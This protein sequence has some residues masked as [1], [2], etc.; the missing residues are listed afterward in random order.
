MME[1]AFVHVGGPAGSG[2][3]TFIEA[4]L[5]GA[6]ALTLVARCLRDDTLARAR[7]DTSPTNPELRRYRQAS[8][9]GAAL[10]TFPGQPAD[11]D[12]FF[13]TNL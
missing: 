13:M 4:M 10:Y 1:R 9:A 3:T 2:K 7:E 6:G 12:D 5:T 11:A 8:A